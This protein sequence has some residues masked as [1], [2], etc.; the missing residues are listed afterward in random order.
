MTELLFQ[1]AL[2]YPR[3]S[4]SA[5]ASSKRC[6]AAYSKCAHYPPPIFMSSAVQS[7]RV[8]KVSIALPDGRLVHYMS[9]LILRKAAPSS[10]RYSHDEWSANGSPIW[11]FIPNRTDL[12]AHFRHIL[13][14]VISQAGLNCLLVTRRGSTSV[15]RWREDKSFIPLA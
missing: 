9:A 3:S 4:K 6:D 15:H 7:R 14:Q 2:L 5:E 8:L 13:R 10:L 1:K 12:G 11:M